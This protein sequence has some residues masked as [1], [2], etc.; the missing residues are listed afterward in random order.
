MMRYR[1]LRPVGVIT[2]QINFLLILLM[3]CSIVS[4]GQEARLVGTWQGAL[5]DVAL[6]LNLKDDGTGALNGEGFRYAVRGNKIVVEDGEGEISAYDFSLEGDSLT[7]SGGKFPRAV[8]FTRSGGSGAA[9]RGASSQ[10]G[11]EAERGEDDGL[12][13][14]WRSDAA[15]VQIFD[16][17]HLTINGERFRYSVEGDT[18]TLSGAEGSAKVRFQLKGDTLVTSYN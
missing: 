2:R 9:R 13:G 8:T 17:G 11:T 1:V 18:I 14:T 3:G 6:S 5:G 16:D 4:W 7:I 12:T 15:T 10:A